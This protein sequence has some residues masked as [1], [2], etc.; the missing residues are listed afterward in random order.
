MYIAQSTFLVK[1][2]QVNAN[3]FTGDASIE[4]VSMFLCC[5]LLATMIVQFVLYL[6]HCFRY[7]TDRN[8][9]NVLWGKLLRMK[10][11]YY[12]KVS[13]NTLLSRIT[14]DT[15]CLNE[16]I[17]DVVLDMFFSVY[18]LILTINEMSSISLKASFALLIFVPLTIIISF[19]MGKMNLKFENKMKYEISNLTEYLSELVSSMPIVKS[20]NRQNYEINRGRKMVD[21]NYQ[22]NRNLIFLDVLRQI[23]STVS[24]MLPDIAII[25]IGIKLLQDSTLTASGW[26]VFYVYSG[27]L[28]AFASQLGSYWESTKKIQGQLNMVSDV[29]NEEEETVQK[30]VDDVVKTG[31]IIFENVKFAYGNHVVLDNISLTIPKNKTTAIVGFSGSGKTTIVK[32]IERIYEPVEGRIMMN[33]S[34]INNIDIKTWRNQ[35]ALVSQN[36]PMISGTIRENVLYGINREVSDEEIMEVAHLVGIEEFIL[37]CPDGLDHQVGQFGEKI[38]GGQRQKLSIARAILVNPEFL[39]LDEPT[40]SL[41]I[42]SANEVAETIEKMKDQ[43]TIVI[44]AH[45]SRILREV[46]HVVY[47]NEL[48]QS[49]EGNREELFQNSVFWSRLME[50]EKEEH[51]YE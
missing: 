31:D 25:L 34:S 10:P 15:S 11:S 5:E 30:Y 41:D 35:I 38:S 14:I 4:S 3:F 49:I 39:I 40:A 17:M 50:A 32:L 26:Y 33:G 44:I 43:M 19:L 27:T 1:I 24:G 20:F 18:T 9:R 51:V 28:I 2:P 47:I 29:L 37:S 7:K 13:A 16:F 21:D 6:N 36:A 12:D 8:L 48:H 23:I 42:V 46:D 45:Q 22:A